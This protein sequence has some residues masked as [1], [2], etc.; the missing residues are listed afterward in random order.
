MDLC[1]LCD[2]LRCPPV[3]VGGKLHTWSDQIGVFPRRPLRVLLTNVVDEGII[4]VS[5]PLQLPNDIGRPDSQ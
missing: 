1:K 4:L 2:S 3:G 5:I